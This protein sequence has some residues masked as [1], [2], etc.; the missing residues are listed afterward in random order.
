MSR[1]ELFEQTF[2]NFIIRGRFSKKMQ[3]CLENV[4]ILATSGCQNCAMITDHRILTAKINIYG[5]CSFHFYH[6]I[7]SNSFPCPQHSEPEKSTPKSFAFVLGVLATSS[8]QNSAMITDRRKLA[9][10]LNLYGMSSF[11]FHCWNQLKLIPLPS[12]FRTRPFLPPNVSLLIIGCVLRTM[13]YICNHQVVPLTICIKQMGAIR[14]ITFT[15][16]NSDCAKITLITD[17]CND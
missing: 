14:P 3:K 2:E 10:K 8:R 13:R 5:M 9:A 11:H 16:K 1:C 15:I 7:N 17:N 4:P 6:G 12:T